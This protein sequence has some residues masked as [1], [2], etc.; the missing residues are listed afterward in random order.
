[1]KGADCGAVCGV[2]CSFT[3]GCGS[4]FSCLANKCLPQ[5]PLRK[6]QGRLQEM[7]ESSLWQYYRGELIINALWLR[8]SL[9]KILVSHMG[10]TKD[11]RPESGDGKNKEL[12]S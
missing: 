7:A 4:T 3:C 6:R 12:R 8:L 2:I 5:H 10:H 11:I 1:M 9:E